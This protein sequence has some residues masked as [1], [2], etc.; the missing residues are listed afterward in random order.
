MRLRKQLYNNN[1]N[2]FY[3]YLDELMRGFSSRR[4][5][6][7]YARIIRELENFRLTPQIANQYSKAKQFS[8]SL[9]RDKKYVEIKNITRD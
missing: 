6:E 1:I 4:T 9:I 8:N 7:S 5:D 3:F 2:E